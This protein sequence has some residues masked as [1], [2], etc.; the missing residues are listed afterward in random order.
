LKHFEIAL[1]RGQR[2]PK[3]EA[4]YKELRKLAGKQ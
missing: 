3:T 2:S 4:E 1:A